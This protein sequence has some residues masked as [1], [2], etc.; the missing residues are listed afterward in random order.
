MIAEVRIKHQCCSSLSWRDKCHGQ[1]PKA[2]VENGAEGP[3]QEFCYFEQCLLRKTN[4]VQ[5]LEH[6]F[7]SD[8]RGGARGKAGDSSDG[9]RIRTCS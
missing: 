7:P 3:D 4:K 9:A 2:Q 1:L 5:L 6:S 8:N